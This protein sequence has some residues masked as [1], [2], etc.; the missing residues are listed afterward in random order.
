MPQLGDNTNLGFKRRKESKPRG[1]RADTMPVESPAPT[2]PILQNI[3]TLVDVSIKPLFNEMW[4]RGRG[5]VAAFASDFLN[6]QLHPGQVKWAHDHFWANERHLSSGNRYG[7]SYIA[8]IKLLH[9]AF[10]QMR[11]PQYAELTNEY[12][13]LNL[14]LTIDMARI[15]TDYC[16][17]MGLD[18]KMFSRFIV[19]NE[20][21]TAPFPVVPIGT[22]KSQRNNQFRSEIW[23]R[24]SAKDARYLLGRKF[25]FVNYDECARD[26]HGDKILDEVL[27]M[28]L[29]DRAGRIDM[30]STAAGRNWFYLAF[31]RG[32]EDKEHL[33]YFSMSGT[34]Y[35][36]PHID[37]DR[38]KQNESVMS[39]VWRNQNIYGGFSDF[40]NVFFRPQ[41]EEMY[42][43]IEYPI[44]TDY[45]LLDEIRVDPDGQYIMSIDWGVKRDKTV[46]MV[47][48]ID[49]G[50]KQAKWIPRNGNCYPL[51]FI[52]GFAT[53]PNGERYAWDELKNIAVLIHRR[54]NDA[55]C[56]FDSTGMAG[57]IIFSE[58]ETMGMK[59]HEGYDFS[60]NE[61][62]AKTQLVMVAQQALQNRLF[63][64][65][66][67]PTTA[68]LVDEL[69]MY[70]RDDK[71]LSTDFV[72]AFCLL[73]ERLRRTNL[74]VSEILSLPL[75]YASGSRRFGGSSLYE[76]SPYEINTGVPRGMPDSG[77]VIVS[78]KGR[79]AVAEEVNA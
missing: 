7:K 14:S 54:F 38:V 8:A 72:F 31:R 32:L 57:S 53:K 60:G 52:Q 40:A 39:E 18:S 78:N 43:S 23:A 70:D 28:R 25:D 75:I 59:H 58:L 12:V 19:E 55:A 10:F 69:M 26:P 5:N 63:V 15:V 21:K 29:A 37:H 66:F 16:L 46:I 77:I 1:H 20:I 62:N 36:N 17:R 49:D 74:P 4:E 3:E 33:H 2:D 22:P 13:A 73:A 42:D 35:D 50:R 79:V 24:S 67:N 9:H 56:M 68:E 51:N 65:P 64:F 44:C 30:T 27:R 45:R 71:H 6:V 76:L 48:R 34:S 41:I 61:G 11:P 47:T